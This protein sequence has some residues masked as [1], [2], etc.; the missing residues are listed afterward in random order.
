MKHNEKNAGYQ[1]SPFHTMCSFLSKSKTTIA[2]I[3]NV[4]STNAHNSD[5]SK[6]VSCG[7]KL[8]VSQK[9]ILESSKLKE[10]ADDNFKLIL[11]KM[12]ESSPKGRK[13]C[14]NRRYCSLRAISP[15]PAVFSKDLNC[16]H[17]KPRACLGVNLSINPLN[18]DMSKSVSFGKE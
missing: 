1:H 7:K 8:S 15:F 17:L 16:R 3:F 14:G 6:I 11:M 2:A 5:M 12:A 9:T 18:S 4:S 10:F 13:H